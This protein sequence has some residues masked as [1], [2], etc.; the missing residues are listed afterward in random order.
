[1]FNLGVAG[2]IDRGCRLRQTV[3]KAVSLGDNLK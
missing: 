3:P 2:Q 1:V